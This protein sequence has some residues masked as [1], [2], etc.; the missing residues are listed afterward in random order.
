MRKKQPRIKVLKGGYKFDR[1]YFQVS[2]IILFCLFVIAWFTQ[3]GGLFENRIYLKC[4]ENGN[5][6]YNPF[7]EQCEEYP[8][9]CENEYFFPG[10][11]I[12]EKP[13]GLAKNFIVLTIMVLLVTFIYNHMKHNK[14]YFD[15]KG[16][17]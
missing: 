13:K 4:P 10:D 2:I 11:E 16:E 8:Q 3:G 1:R 14:K 7:Y 9:Y 12:G 15:N 5:N 17:I 6:C